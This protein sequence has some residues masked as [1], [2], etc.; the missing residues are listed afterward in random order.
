MKNIGSGTA[1]GMDYAAFGTGGRA[2][3]V[4]PGLSDGLATVRGKALAL[5]PPYLPYLKKHRVYMFSRRNDLKIGD[6]IDDMARCQL[7][8]LDE[9]EVEKFFVLGVSEGGMIAASLAL[10]A[11]ERVERLVLAV[12]AAGVN[13]TLRD[14]I[15]R[16]LDFADRG[17]HG[18]LMRDTAERSYSEGYLKALRK[19]YPLLGLVGKP[20]SY[21]RFRANC[22]A[23]LGFEKREKLGNISCPTLVIGGGRDKIVGAD[24]A[25]E[26]HALIPGSELY[27]YPDLGHGLYE[28][29]GDFYKRAFDFIDK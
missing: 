9:L 10:I 8:A 24:A 15:A 25:P 4:L 19:T 21:D 17:D 11:P 22:E 26:L 20:K 29:S 12:S 5:L 6:A 13:D 2:V 28:E 14:N 23:I 3:I 18:A 7:R 27:I 1:C 16:W